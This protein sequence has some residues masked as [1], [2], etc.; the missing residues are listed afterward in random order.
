MGERPVSPWGTVGGVIPTLQW[1][2]LTE[3]SQTWLLSFYVQQPARTCSSSCSSSSFS[4]SCSSS[5]LSSSSTVCLVTGSMQSHTFVGRCYNTLLETQML[6]PLGVGASW[7]QDRAWF[8]GLHAQ[9]RQFQNTATATQWVVF[10]VFV[11]LLMTI[12]T[13]SIGNS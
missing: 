10:Q 12:F 6:L 7:L 5:S 8:C 2:L 11:C 1:G 4:S 9:K 13:V 3:E